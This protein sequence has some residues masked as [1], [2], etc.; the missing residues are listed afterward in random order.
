MPRGKPTNVDALLLQSIINSEEKT[1]NPEGGITKFCIHCADLYNKCNVPEQITDKLI[2]S[3]IKTGNGLTTRY[4]AAI[5]AEDGVDHSKPAVTP[6]PTIL[7]ELV[8]QLSPAYKLW[9]RE[10]YG[11]LQ[12]ED[13]TPEGPC[14]REG[15][16]RWWLDGFL[17]GKGLV[18][19][20]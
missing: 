11:Q 17:R 20:D 10:D 4:G 6:T 13:G 12:L 15:A 18:P 2:Y 1:F 5:A 9:F 19:R 8:D 16:L 14:L 3:R 7:S